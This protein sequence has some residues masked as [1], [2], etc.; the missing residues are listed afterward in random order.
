MQDFLTT[1]RRALKPTEP[2]VLLASGAK[3]A[4]GENSAP[5]VAEVK[6]CGSLLELL[7]PLTGMVLRR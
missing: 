7:T 4:E 3:K 6:N 5:S 2:S 1:S